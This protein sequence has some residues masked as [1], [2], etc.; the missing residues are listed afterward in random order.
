MEN[1]IRKNV[2]D[3]IRVKILF[4]TLLDSGRDV[5]AVNARVDALS[6]FHFLLSQDLERTIISVLLVLLVRRLPLIECWTTT[7]GPGL[8]HDDA[9]LE[10]QAAFVPNES[11]Q[12]FTDVR[13][14]DHPLVREVLVWC[15]HV[16]TNCDAAN[17]HTRRAIGMDMMS[18]TADKQA[19]LAS[20]CQLFE[21]VNALQFGTIVM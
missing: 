20:S 17:Y 4:Q 3:S 5:T 1:A 12:Y 15:C 13:A 2:I 19:D 16:T 9:F 8:S 21:T 7:L 18:S 10:D 14:V 11:V 6:Q